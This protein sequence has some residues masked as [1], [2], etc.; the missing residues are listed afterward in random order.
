MPRQITLVYALMLVAAPASAFSGDINGYG[1]YEEF[2]SA[3]F[4]FELR[5][6][7]PSQDAN[8]ILS[9]NSEKDLSVRVLADL[10]SS[11]QW[12]RFWSQNISINQNA[13]LSDPQLNTLVEICNLLPEFRRGDLIEF[14]SAE[15]GYT[16]LKINGQEFTKIHG[17]CGADLLLPAL[18][19]ENPASGALKDG[20][21]GLTENSLAANLFANTPVQPDRKD[22]LARFATPAIIAADTE[23]EYESE[24]ELETESES[25]SESAPAEDAADNLPAT[26]GFMAMSTPAHEAEGSSEGAHALLGQE[27]VRAPSHQS[28]GSAWSNLFEH[29]EF[30][31]DELARTREARQEIEA[32]QRGAN[33]QRQV[34]SQIYSKLQYPQSALIR[35]Q[36]SELQLKLEIDAYGN[37][38]SVQTV[39]ESRYN[40][41][42]REALR[43]VQASA[44]YEIPPGLDEQHKSTNIYVPIRFS[45]N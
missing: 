8:S 17:I 31:I 7:E 37:L 15:L 30:N 13:A 24:L 41:L 29:D 11:R 3:Q 44:P 25:E 14:L 28:S 23:T 34:L 20:L 4:A 5:L 16:L 43:A 18:L 32:A 39:E 36:Q 2:G 22:L 38:L 27:L 9:N 33:Y 12:C 35:G 21:L 1:I 40:A 42:N 6:Q 26:G 19:G 10:L 45:L